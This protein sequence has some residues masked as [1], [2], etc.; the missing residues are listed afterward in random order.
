MIG[1]ALSRKQME[2]VVNKMKGVDQPWDCP[3]GR[4]TI[5]HVTNLGHTLF[6]DALRETKYFKDFDLEKL[7]EY[8]KA[9]S[10]T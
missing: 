6:Q 2:S 7:T 9:V 8:E 1:D 4:P 5:R 10:S 3:H